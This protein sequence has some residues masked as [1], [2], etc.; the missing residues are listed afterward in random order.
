VPIELRDAFGG[1]QIRVLDARDLK[2]CTIQ[3]N[4]RRAPPQEIEK[5]LRVGLH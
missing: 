5:G 2:S 4:R 1:I 3:L